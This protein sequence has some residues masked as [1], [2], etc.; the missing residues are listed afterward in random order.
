MKQPSPVSTHAPP[1]APAFNH[2]R[3]ASV[4]AAGAGIVLAGLALAACAHEVAPPADE[5]V[6]VGTHRLQVHPEGSGEPVVVIDAGITD[7]LEKL[8]PLQLQLAR[9]T[10]VITYNRAGYGGSEPGPLPRDAGREAEE[11]RAMLA[12]AA[13]PPPWVLV[14][15]SLGALN[16]QLLASRYPADVAG[17]VLLDPPPVSFLLGEQHAGFRQTAD[18]LTTSWQAIADS[19]AALPDP[20]SRRTAAF[21]QAIASEHREMFGESARL[22]AGIRSFDDLPLAVLAAGYPNPALGPGAA[23]FQQFWTEQSRLLAGK[24]ARGRFVLAEDAS[25]YLYL[26]APEV[27]VENILAVVRDARER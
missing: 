23:E 24:S 14:G 4:P 19:A 10:R 16:V 15:H 6:T 20:E 18:S 3:R 21:F 12:A 27:V 22:A 5:L 26:D 11:I 9:T 25:H 1:P 7:Q 17:L 2:R 13:V 8:R